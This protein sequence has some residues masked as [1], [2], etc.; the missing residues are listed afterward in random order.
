MGIS[1]N[2]NERII[3]HNSGGVKSTKSY[4]PWEI[5]HTEDVGTYKE[6]TKKEKYYKSSAGRRKLKELL[7]RKGK[8]E[9]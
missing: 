8:I 4:A 5:I 6:A 7:I 9:K 2:V 3:K 1:E